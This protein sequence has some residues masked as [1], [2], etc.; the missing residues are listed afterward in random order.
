MNNITSIIM[1]IDAWVAEYLLTILIKLAG[2]Q[3]PGFHLNRVSV[4]RAMSSNYSDA[5]PLYIDAGKVNDLLN[6]EELVPAIEQA[7]VDFSK[8]DGSIV[9]PVRS[10]VPVEQHGFLGVMPGY[11]RNASSLATKLVSFY[12]E[13]ADKGL[14]THMAKIVLFDPPTGATLAIMD[15]GVITDLRTAAAS[16]VATKYLSSKDASVLAI[17]G[18]GS[19][20]RSHVKLLRLVRNFKEIRAWS[21]TLSHVQEFAKE[22]NA[23]VCESPQEAVS[24]ADVIVTVTMAVEPVLFRVWVKP[25]AHINGK[26]VN[27]ILCCL[28]L[29]CH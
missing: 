22:V 14:P 7:L 6:P 21:P 20:A 4:R 24:G 16:A 19:Q 17:L 12:P 5:S 18:S 27:Y 11:S 9:Q 23:I 29:Y 15:G 26:L 25:G 2:N 3:H 28:I 8:R 13:N 1:K 10:V